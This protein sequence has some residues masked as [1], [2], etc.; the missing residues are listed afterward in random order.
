MY[1]SSVEAVDGIIRPLNAALNQFQTHFRNQAVRAGV[2]AAGE[3]IK[4]MMEQVIRFNTKPGKEPPIRRIRGTNITV[5]RPHLRDSITNKVWKIPDS[6]G[7]INYIGPISVQVPHAHWFE[8]G[9][10]VRYTRAGAYRGRMPAY[11]V[12]TRTYQAS[13]N[14]ALSAMEAALKAKME[15]FKSS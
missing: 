8:R 14:Q 10:A 11:F 6:N 15:S 5:S 4:R 7:Y 12:L 1:R 2:V 9:T 13:M 3:P